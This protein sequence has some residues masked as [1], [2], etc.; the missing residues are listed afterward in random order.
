QYSSKIRR[1][2]CEHSLHIIVFHCPH[3]LRI[4]RLE[5]PSYGLCLVFN[6][7][8]ATFVLDHDQVVLSVNVER[9]QSHNHK[10]YNSSR[11]RQIHQYHRSNRPMKNGLEGVVYIRGAT[12]SAASFEG[13]TG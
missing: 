1:N 11:Q 8:H 6:D 2:C 12:L 9:E 5:L 3:S 4:D 10:H 13:M 7:R